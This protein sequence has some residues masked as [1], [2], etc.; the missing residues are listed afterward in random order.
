MCILICILGNTREVTN[1]FIPGR[2]GGDL[3]VTKV[4]VKSARRNLLAVAT[5]EETSVKG[6]LDF[7]KVSTK[8][9]NFN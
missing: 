4:G 1:F 8:K 6:R 3:V 5:H 2:D 7:I 9:T